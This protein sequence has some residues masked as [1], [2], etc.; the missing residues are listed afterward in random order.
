[1]S[2]IMLEQFDVLRV[3]FSLHLCAVHQKLNLCLVKRAELFEFGGGGL[4][5][6]LI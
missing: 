2:E 3:L 5:S 4:G 6:H 1:M